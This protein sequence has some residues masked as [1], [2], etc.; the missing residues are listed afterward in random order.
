MPMPPPPRWP[1]W[2]RGVQEG[3]LGT[4]HSHDVVGLQP[5][6]GWGVDEDV[7]ERVLVVVH[8]VCKGDRPG[9][10]SPRK[11]A[12]AVGPVQLQHLPPPSWPS[13]LNPRAGQ[14]SSTGQ[15]P[16]AAATGS[17]PAASMSG[18]CP[19]QEH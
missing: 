9:R 4:Q 5:R 17:A 1:A 2:G 18:G 3:S 16:G 10:R 7:G 12:G 6:V 8:L 13:R 15:P 19:E 11:P 14:V